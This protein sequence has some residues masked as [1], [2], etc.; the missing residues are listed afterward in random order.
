MTRKNDSDERQQPLVKPQGGGAAAKPDVKPGHLRRLFDQVRWRA[1][2]IAH[3][4]WWLAIG[5]PMKD[6]PA[7]SR[8]ETVAWAWRS[9]RSSIMFPHERH[10]YRPISELIE[11]LRSKD[12][13]ERLDS[14]HRGP[15]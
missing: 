6:M 5:A 3:I 9:W 12:T 15:A 7:G 4:A 10:R 8:R 13:G 1:L 14:E 11:E 2:A